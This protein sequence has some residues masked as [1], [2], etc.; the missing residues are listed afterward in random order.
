MSTAKYIPSMDKYLLW[1]GGKP[2]FATR[3]ELEACCCEPSCPDCTTCPSPITATFSGL[4]GGTGCSDL[5]GAWELTYQTA[6][7]WGGGTGFIIVT[8]TC[9]GGVWQLDVT[10][11][12]YSAWARFT[13]T[14]YGDCAPASGWVQSAGTCTGGS[15]SLAW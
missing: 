6:C 11:P 15:A 12:L 9:G 10:Y 4:G 1:Q 2:K 14:T 13:L 7:T 5:N 8:L 3:A